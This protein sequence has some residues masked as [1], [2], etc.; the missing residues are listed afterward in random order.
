M[1][2]RLSAYKE[3]IIRAAQLKTQITAKKKNIQLLN[4]ELYLLKDELQAI[5][6]AQRE[7]IVSHSGLWQD[8]NEKIKRDFSPRI[9]KITVDAITVS[10][11]AGWKISVLFSIDA[12]NN[13]FLKLAGKKYYTYDEPFKA[14]LRF[15]IDDIN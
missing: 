14:Q 8:I 10:S 6:H 15:K 7:A 3:L 1:Y 5:K 4:G 11:H 9:D 2:T 13:V 12:K